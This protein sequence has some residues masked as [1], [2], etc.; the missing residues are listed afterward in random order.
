MLL[1]MSE[2]QHIWALGHLGALALGLGTLAPE[3]LG[4]WASGRLGL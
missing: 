3:H 2:I 4:T 1:S